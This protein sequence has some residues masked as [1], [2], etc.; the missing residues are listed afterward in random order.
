MKTLATSWLTALEDSALSIANGVVTIAPAIAAAIVIMV[1]GW[2]FARSVRSL[3]RQLSNGANRLLDRVFQKGELANVRFSAAAISAVAE[4]AFWIIIFLAITVAARIAGFTAIFG[5]MNQLVAH[6]P[7]L[8][9]GFLIIA[10]GYFASR[11]VGRH[12]AASARDEKANENILIG[13]VVQGFIFLTALIIGLDQVGVKVSFLITLLTV[14]AGAILAGFSIAFGLGAKD[15]V[16][17]LFG[18]RLAHRS[19]LLGLRVRI[20]EIEG[21]VLDVSANHIALDTVSGRALIPAR[22]VDEQVVEILTATGQ[23]NNG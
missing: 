20:G 11:Y 10:L 12:I 22:I 4:T 6:L 9:V 19:L 2:L 14:A 21:D 3:V 1:L 17:N 16:R 23:G 13:R 8:V 5:W 7:N 15:H 18:A